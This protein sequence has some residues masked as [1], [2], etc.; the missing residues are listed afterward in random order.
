MRAHRLSFDITT[1]L[2]TSRHFHENRTSG[3]VFFSSNFLKPLISIWEDVIFPTLYTYKLV[4][5]E[6]IIELSI[7]SFLDV[8][9]LN[10][11]VWS[12][13]LFEKSFF[14]HFLLFPLFCFRKYSFIKLLKKLSI[15]A[16]WFLAKI[17]SGPNRIQIP[18]LFQ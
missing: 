15:R 5:S 10:F 8:S 17:H 9:V 11:D 18:F 16:M 6:G 14:V 12:Q 2:L 3:E 4:F 13:V 1:A 7:K